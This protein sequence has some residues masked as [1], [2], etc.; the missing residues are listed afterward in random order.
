MRCVVADDSLLI[1]EGV[2]ALLVAQG[3]DV[4]ATAAD[5]SHLIRE[6]A[7]ARPD[8][9]LV[10][11]RMPPTHT[12]EGLRAAV[13]IRREYPTVAVVVLSQY[14]D[15]AYA[16]RLLTEVPR[17]VGY[18]LKD[19]ITDADALADAITRVV[20]GECMV[21]PAI[22]ARL[23]TRRRS[24]G[25]LDGLTTRER[26]VLALVAEGRSNAAI[27]RM[28]G[29]TA[30]TLEDHVRQIFTKL[31]LLESADD[32]RRVLAVVSYLRATDE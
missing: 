2:S 21:D 13:R 17:G 28:L 10:D 16:H 23:L 5:A 9:A 1:R 8:V 4:V 27:S 26:E 20:Q 3:W 19:R 30:K 31:R 29:I 18:L 14:L 25:P 15:S 24:P 32:N 22:V 6:I 7:L 12:D 11:I